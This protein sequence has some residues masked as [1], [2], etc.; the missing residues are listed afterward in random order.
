MM[1]TIIFSMRV[2]ISFPLC[3][4]EMLQ[5]VAH[6]VS[7]YPLRVRHCLQ[8]CLGARGPMRSLARMTI[9]LISRR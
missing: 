7:R 3:T 6:S 2:V 1:V 9:Q 8:Q 5:L 4:Y